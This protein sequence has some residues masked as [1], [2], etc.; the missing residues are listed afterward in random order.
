MGISSRERAVALA[1]LASGMACWGA[2][3]AIAPHYGD[4]AFDLGSI[5]YIAP[6]YGTFALFHTVLGGAGVLLV[7][8]GLARLVHLYRLGPRLAAMV[9]APDRSFVVAATLLAG[10]LPVLVRQWVLQ[11]APLADDES[12]YRFMAEV[13]ASGSVT[14]PSP[15]PRVLFDRIFMVNDGRLYAQ[16]FLG[17]PA[18]LAP[19]TAA[20]LGGYLNAALSALTVPGVFY[21]ARRVTGRGWARLTVVLFVLAPLLFI[22]AATELSHTSCLFMLVWSHAGLERVRERTGDDRVWVHGAF[23]LCLAAAFFIRPLTA[24][25]IGIPLFLGWARAVRG[26]PRRK[27]AVA[28]F[29]VPALVL[30]VAFLAVNAIQTGNPLR[31]A[32]QQVYAYAKS[33]DYLFTNWWPGH[34]AAVRNMQF[35]K[36][37]EVLALLGAGLVRLNT[38]LFGWP[39]SLAFV[40]FAF[41]LR[42]AR[43]PAACAGCFLL[44]HLPL[45]DIGID[46]FGPVHYTELAWPIVLLTTLGVRAT[47]A[48]LRRMAPTL[49]WGAAWPGAAVAASVMAALSLYVPVR[50]S[51]LADIAR[52]VRVPT[53]AVHVAAFEQPVVVFAP[54]PFTPRCDPHAHVPAHFVHWRPNNDPGLQNDVLWVNHLSVKADREM[55]R[56]FP[57]RTGWILHYVDCRPRLESIDEVAPGAV[58]NGWIRNQMTATGMIHERYDDAT[59]SGIR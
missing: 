14:A 5:T 55:M 16:Y 28:A 30:G 59:R 51:N 57:D 10:L 15:E 38:A 29:C 13:L 31:P 9:A 41:G 12:A 32:Y 20:G 56:H 21:V 40:P 1:T 50:L 53:H 58:P 19:A 46:S 18:L 23:A 44:L 26:D 49:G 34:D 48:R 37:G 6:V 33:N 45:T 22:G 47:R 7:A 52:D 17:W 2:V 54:R 39:V 24:L 25:G 35:E 27:A 36:P 11:G 43:M 4:F 42:A 8:T 3:L